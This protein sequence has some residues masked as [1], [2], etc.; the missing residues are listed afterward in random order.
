M[1]GLYGVTATASDAA[2]TA[3]F[4]QGVLRG[5][6]GGGTGSNGIGVWAKGNLVGMFSEVPGTGE[7]LVL[8]RGAPASN[9]IRASVLG[10][11]Q[12]RFWVDNEGT[13]HAQVLE[14]LGGSDLSERFDVVDDDAVEPGTV[15]SIDGDNEG[16]LE[17]SREP[18]DHRVAGIVSGAGGSGPECS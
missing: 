12:D 17:V 8:S 16:R 18:Y 13:T 15:V 7:N 5:A 10:D 4:G 9:F 14:I 6:Y 1:G 3:L 11:P 2:S